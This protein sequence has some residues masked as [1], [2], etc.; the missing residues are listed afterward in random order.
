M[1]ERY[2]EGVVYFVE[3][4]PY[5]TQQ[6][7]SLSHDSKKCKVK[8]LSGSLHSDQWKNCCL[9]W[10]K[11]AVPLEGFNFC[12]P[13]DCHREAACSSCPL[14]DGAC[15]PCRTISVRPRLLGQLII[16]TQAPA[17][18]QKPLWQD[19]R[20][21]SIGTTSSSNLFVPS[22]PFLLDQVY[23]VSV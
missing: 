19:W 17:G 1:L 7:T 3:E 23:A 18:T 15:I 14:S 5:P 2:L 10:W 6:F 12:C 20:G 11:P 4:S 22:G 16:R 13:S 21:I 8:G 9:S